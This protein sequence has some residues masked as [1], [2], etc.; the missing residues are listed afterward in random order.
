MRLFYLPLLAGLLG[1]P[2]LIGCGHSDEEMGA[3]QREID[4]RSA[5]LKAAK[6]AH[7][8]AKDDLKKAQDEIEKLRQDLGLQQSQNAEE[9]ARRTAME[10]KLAL[11]EEAK[12]RFRA[13]KEKL[14]QLKAKGID[15]IVRDGRMIISLPGDVLFDSGV[16]VLKPEGKRIL[17]QVAD[18]IRNDQGLASRNFQ[19]AG[20][21]DNQE[22]GPG[23]WRDNW[24]LSVA[25]ARTVVVY[26]TTADR[27][28]GQPGGPGGGG[29]NPHRWSAAGYSKYAPLVGT[30]EKQ[31]A[32]EMRK[33]RRVELVL[34]PNVEEL[35]NSLDKLGE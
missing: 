31:S 33:N 12:A 9:A 17:G 25:R 35:L 34:Q 32:D 5:E 30:D 4:A 13:L 24:G 10:R 29:L 6:L 8:K 19:V 22:Y 27:R 15:V 16:E 20:H 26:L 14:Q 28:A 18:V 23:P 2:V 21:T 1:A 11:L 3:K 7:E